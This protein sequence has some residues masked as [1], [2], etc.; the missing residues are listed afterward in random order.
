MKKIKLFKTVDKK[1]QDI[2]FKKI[3]DD[4]YCVVYERENKEFS[5]VQ[6]L[7]IVHKKNGKHIIQSYDKNLFDIQ[8]V[9]NTCVGLTYYETKLILKKMREKGWKSK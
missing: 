6:V 9:G 5:Y 2:G 8:N 4:V 1:L 3:K 7:T